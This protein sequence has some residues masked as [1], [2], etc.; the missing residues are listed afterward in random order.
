MSDSADLWENVLKYCY[1]AAVGVHNLLWQLLL[2]GVQ[3]TM[4]SGQ[5]YHD[6]PYARDP[7][8]YDPRFDPRMDPRHSRYQVRW[9]GIITQDV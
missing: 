9:L 4:R 7:R 5:P 8:R 2:Y 1:A 6:G 3:R